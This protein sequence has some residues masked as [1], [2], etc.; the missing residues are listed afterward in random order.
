MSS[1]HKADLKLTTDVQL[2]FRTGLDRDKATPVDLH[3]FVQDGGSP[4]DS[5][6]MLPGDG[7]PLSVYLPFTRKALSP[8]RSPSSPHPLRT[9]AALA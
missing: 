4:M 9:C 1:T 7:P 5:I 8:V 6:R 3:S 2:D